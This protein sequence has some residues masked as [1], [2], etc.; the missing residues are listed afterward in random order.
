MSPPKCYIPVEFRAIVHPSTSAT[1]L[2]CGAAFGAAALATVVALPACGQLLGIS[3]WVDVSGSPDATDGAAIETGIPP[4]GGADG[5]SAA[6]GAEA[7]S[8]GDG[9]AP[10]QSPVEGGGGGV[11]VGGAFPFC[12]DST[13]TTVGLYQR[14]LDDPAV[15]P[16]QGQPP[17]CGWNT[18]YVPSY[19]AYSGD[20]QAALKPVTA[21]DWC[22]ARAF[23]GY[24][25]KHLC[26]NRL[27]AGAVDTD[28]ALVESEWYYACAGPAGNAYPY[29]NAYQPGAC[30]ANLPPDAGAGVVPT[31]TCVGS[32]PGLYDMSGNL[33]EWENS[34]IP[35][36]TGDAGDDLCTIRGGT[37]FFAPDSVTCALR[38]GGALNRRNESDTSAVT[39]RCCWEP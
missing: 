26:G 31:S 36:S 17:Q 28:A 22:D 32:V 30:R 18:S 6:D 4:E 35:S 8:A 5:A 34:C 23:C 20:P 39:I 21:I 1:S 16:A 15:S 9:A 14:F 13:E 33:A 3:S 19:D 27:D 37:F 10:C 29:G 24:W 2:A 11:L 25:G 12:I 38:T 7:A